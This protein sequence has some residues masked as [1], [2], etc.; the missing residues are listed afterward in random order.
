MKSDSKFIADR[1]NWEQMPLLRTL[2]FT[3][4]GIAL[5]FSII[6]MLVGTYFINQRANE[7]QNSRKIDLIRMM[8][9]NQ[10]KIRL[11]FSLGMLEASN[12]ALQETR[13][14]DFIKTVDVKSLSEKEFRKKTESNDVLVIPE[15]ID[16]TLPLYIVLRLKPAKRSGI[17]SALL[18]PLLILLFILA[19]IYSSIVFIMKKIFR[20]LSLLISDEFESISNDRMIDLGAR[21]EMGVL[22]SKIQE[23]QRLKIQMESEKINFKLAS[24]LAHD[25]RSPLEVLKG[26]KEEMSFFPD[27]TRRRIQ[28]SITRIEEITFNL[29]RANR[30]EKVHNDLN[31]NQDLL[32]LLMS[33]VTEKKIEF[34]NNEKVEVLDVLGP[35]SF[36]LFSIANRSSLMSIISNLINNAIESFDNNP[37]IVQIS[38]EGFLN[39]NVIKI[40]DN[41]PGIPANIVNKLFSKGFTTKKNGNGLG[42]VNAKQDIE[43]FGGTLSFET[44]I[45]IGTTFIISL[46][47]FEIPDF[48]T[49]SI[50]IYKY[51]KIIILDDDPAF[52]DMWAKRLDNPL[53]KMEHFFSVDEIFSKYQTLHSKVLLLSDFDLLNR[54]F[55]GID[56]IQKLDHAQFSILVTARSEEVEIRERCIKGGIKLLPKSLVNYIKVIQDNSDTNGTSLP[57][58]SLVIL[59][60]DDK[61]IRY[62][63]SVYCEKRGIPFRAFNSID[64]F[65]EVKDTIPKEAKIYI[66]SNLGYDVRGEVES[67]KIFYLG[68]KNLYLATGYSEDCIQ[69]P[70]WIIKIY[71]K[72]PESITKENFC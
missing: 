68:F 13:K 31:E 53:L 25:I 28:L 48:F 64:S 26:L 34:R 65:I 59:I 30:K 61:L 43:A 42:L 52:H 49:E 17:F 21:G 12:L 1:I 6:A 33:V 18:I 27:Q 15:N 69:K 37:G 57:S 39:D 14:I 38:L 22:I 44:E 67:E 54:E 7:I 32:S 40:S 72:R 5:F 41:G 10:E 56:V 4:V 55:D 58:H 35:E 60:D 62:N 23:G 51:E 50:P 45:G 36:G 71:S 11:W 63:W 47:K 3:Q 8:S 46:P 9:S 2:V 19:L 24:Q 66:D 20:P 29:L 16:K 70:S